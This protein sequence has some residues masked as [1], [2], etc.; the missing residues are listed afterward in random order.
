MFSAVLPYFDRATIGQYPYVI[1][2]HGSVFYE[3]STVKK[4]A[5]E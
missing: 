3:R 1:R 5:P 4:L 2:L